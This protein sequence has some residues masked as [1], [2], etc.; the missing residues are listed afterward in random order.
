MR[1]R[2]ATSIRKRDPSEV[3]GRDPGYDEIR[4]MSD[5]SDFSVQ[6]IDSDHNLGNIGN[7][8]TNAQRYAMTPRPLRRAG[9]ISPPRPAH[10]LKKAATTFD[11]IIKNINSWES[12]DP[13][14]NQTPIVPQDHENFKKFFFKE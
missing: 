14:E 9:R 6:K 11:D 7:V 8:A 12:Y 5:D 3:Y 13:N 4:D 1:R 2:K 10:P